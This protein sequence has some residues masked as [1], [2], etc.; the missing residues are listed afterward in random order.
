MT[1]GTGHVAHENPASQRKETVVARRLGR[2]YTRVVR[3]RVGHVMLP[4]TDVF[5]HYIHVLAV[6]QAAH[7]R[8]PDRDI[9]RDLAAREKRAENVHAKEC[10]KGVHDRPTLD[11]CKPSTMIKTVLHK[12]VDKDDAIQAG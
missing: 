10:V 5:R 11:T 8:I 4:S 2:K 1:R 9:N 7:L 6:Q 12:H 3:C